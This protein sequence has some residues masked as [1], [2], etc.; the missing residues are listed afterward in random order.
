MA[1]GLQGDSSPWIKLGYSSF[2]LERKWFKAPSS[3]IVLFEKVWGVGVS[4]LTV[5]LVEN[6]VVYYTMMCTE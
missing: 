6:N 3:T 4:I 5:Q 2:F 1:F